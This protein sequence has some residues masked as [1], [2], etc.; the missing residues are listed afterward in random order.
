MD[1]SFGFRVNLDEEFAS[2]SAEVAFLGYADK[3]RIVDTMSEDVT[4]SPSISSLPRSISPNVIKLDIIPLQYCPSPNIHPLRYPSSKPSPLSLLSPSLLNISLFAPEEKISLD[5]HSTSTQ[6]DNE[7]ES[8]TQDYEENSTKVDNRHRSKTLTTNTVISMSHDPSAVINKCTDDETNHV[9]LPFDKEAYAKLSLM[10]R[11]AS[12]NYSLF[13]SG[14]TS[15]NSSSIS[16]D[17][18]R[19]VG[20]TVENM[21][22]RNHLSAPHQN[23]SLNNSFSSSFDSHDNDTYVPRGVM[24][25]RRLKAVSSLLDTAPNRITLNNLTDTKNILQNAYE[26]TLLKKNNVCHDSTI[27]NNSKCNGTSKTT[28]KNDYKSICTNKKKNCISQ[29]NDHSVVSSIDSNDAAASLLTM[30]FGFRTFPQEQNFLCTSSNPTMDSTHRA[31]NKNFYHKNL[32][33]I[34]EVDCAQDF[35]RKF[36]S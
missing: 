20:F 3:I 33:S 16:T 5:F 4:V 14:T 1:S 34:K 30:A 8:N 18:G 29:I 9:K 31:T 35:K 17:S 19:N 7:G 28:I 23:D 10:E 21:N 32:N 12:Q 11:L 26:S 13:A 36:N 22:A 24:L 25:N 6:S 2:S 15:C 27:R